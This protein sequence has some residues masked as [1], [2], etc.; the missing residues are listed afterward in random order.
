[1]VTFHAVMEGLGIDRLK[2]ADIFFCR[3]VAYRGMV[4]ETFASLGAPTHDWLVDLVFIVSD[5]VPGSW[6][7]FCQS[8]L[9]SHVSILLILFYLRKSMIL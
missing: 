2:L 4:V 1:M 3:H 5:S 9:P 8:K 7:E 6:P